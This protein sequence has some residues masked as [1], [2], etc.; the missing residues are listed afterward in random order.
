MMSAAPTLVA[1]CHSL[2]PEGVLVAM[3]QPGGD[4]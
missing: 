4:S 2:P 1:S 3:G